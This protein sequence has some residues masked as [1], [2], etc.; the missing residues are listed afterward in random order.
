MITVRNYIPGE[1]VPW[2]REE[3]GWPLEQ[4]EPETCWVVFDGG[5]M[6][7]LLLAAR[8]LN[9]LFLLRLLGGRGSKGW[10][11]PLWMAVKDV[12][13]NRKIAGFWTCLDNDLVTERKLMALM[14][15]GRGSSAKLLVSNDNRTWVT[16]RF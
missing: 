6:V 9:T 5:R 10:M 13:D 16:G 15:E 2:S 4:C 14:R 12:C 1:Y 8:M 11:R 7:G 3:I